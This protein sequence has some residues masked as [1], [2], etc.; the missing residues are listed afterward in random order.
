MALMYD[1]IHR[2]KK[3]AACKGL[4][5]NYFFDYYEDNLDIRQEMDRLCQSC[6]VAKECFVSAKFFKESGLWGGIFLEEGEVS[7]EMNDHKDTHDW[8]LTYKAL[9][10]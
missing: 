3:R 9:M 10:E 6:P 2:W 8:F 1:P 7:G 4:D 5:T